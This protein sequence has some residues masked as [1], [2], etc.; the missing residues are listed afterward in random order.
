MENSK[1]EWTDH[2]FNPWE[3]CDKVGPGC[4]NCYAETRN[5]RF[6]GGQAI[7]WGP[8]AP[9]RRTSASNW[10]KPL[11]WDAAYRLQKSAWDT[12]KAENPA[13]TDQAMIDA[14]F[15]KPVRPRVFC[16]SLADVFDNKVPDQWRSDLLRLIEQTPNLDWLVLTK[17]IGNVKRML[18]NIN[19]ERLP[20]NVW[21]GATIVNQQ[22]AD[23]DIPKLLDVDARIRFLSM[24][25]LLGAVDLKLSRP[26][27]DD[28]RQDLDG[29]CDTIITQTG[30]GL[31]WIIVGGESGTNA[32][33]MHPDWARDIMKQ[34]A[35]A[36]TPF[37]FKQW[38]E[39]NDQMI[40]VGKK[41]TGRML[42][43]KTYD[44]YPKGAS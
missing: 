40:R 41:T 6:N 25:P 14:G 27:R 20:S 16:A 4:D 35:K 31:H 29:Y 17:R 3:G 34:C 8:S 22:E 23:R 39:H 24:E 33:P 43:G 32:R 10:N 30:T 38:G 26:A 44:E 12:F 9:R 11:K 21:L 37:L 28:D 36:G 18:A 5:S 19:V 13:L 2:T 1:I 7:N 42:D 15:I